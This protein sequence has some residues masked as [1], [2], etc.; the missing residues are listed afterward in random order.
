[1]MEEEGLSLE[2]A[3]KKIWMVDSK[4]LIVKDR[5][6]GG[7]SSHKAHYAQKHEPIKELADVVKAIKPTVLIGMLMCYCYRLST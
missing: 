5:P 3:R 7:I 2:E 4:G 1:M 6:E